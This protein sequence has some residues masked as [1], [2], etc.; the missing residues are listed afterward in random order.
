M[1]KSFYVVDNTNYHPRI[2]TPKDRI[3]DACM[4]RFNQN[5]ASNLLKYGSLACLKKDEFVNMFQI[6]FDSNID[7]NTAYKSIEFKN[8]LPYT[9]NLSSLVESI[10]VPQIT[11]CGEQLI[12]NYHET[13][14]QLTIHP[15][16]CRL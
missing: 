14:C 5:L 12:K 10:K 8:N 9:P 13:I 6:S 2:L 3:L 1:R 15:C 11:E 16:S 4:T 7:W